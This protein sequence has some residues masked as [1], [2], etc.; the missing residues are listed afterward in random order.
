MTVVVQRVEIVVAT[1][2]VLLIRVLTGLVLVS[3]SAVVVGI[4]VL[5]SVKL[6]YIAKNQ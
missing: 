6:T 2:G 1:A 4:V 5:V 3:V